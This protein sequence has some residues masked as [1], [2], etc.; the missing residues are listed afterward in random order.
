MSSS[1]STKYMVPACVGDYRLEPA[2]IGEGSDAFVLRAIHIPTGQRVAVKIVDVAGR[3]E[4]KS[5]ILTEVAALSLL[6]PN[7]PNVIGFLGVEERRDKIFMF[8]EL[9]HQDLST[10]IHRVGRL[11]EDTA[12]ALFQQAAR[13]VHHCHQHGY[14][15]H[16]VK[17]ENILLTP[18][19]RSV[20]LI[21]FGLSRQLGPGSM[22]ADH[23]GGSPLFMAPE[24]MSLQ[25]HNHSVDIWALG[26]C[27]YFMVTD[28]F[29]WEAESYPELEGKVL[30]DPVSFPDNFGLS[31]N[32]QDLLS[33]MLCKDPHHR[34]S[35]A[36]V[37]AHSWMFGSRAQPPLPLP[38][39]NDEDDALWT[40]PSDSP[41]L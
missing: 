22:L 14:V 5:R 30:F 36:E 27:L 35:L 23:F 16:D 9:A 15:H 21:D 13:A 39:P 2:R 38:L 10:Y 17:L 26:V 18:D 11:D 25:P 3:P 8:M 24:I 33:R 28:S 31:W 29:P 41:P 19:A 40:R 6:S 7:C 1:S 32:L 12:R 4:V 20:R 37:L 34:I